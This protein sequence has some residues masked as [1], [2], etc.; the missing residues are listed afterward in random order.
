MSKISLIIPCYNEEKN[1]KPLFDE[2]SRLQ[3]KIDVELVIINNGSKD[4]TQKEIHINKKKIKKIKI[5]NI[6][7]NIGFGNGVKKGLE[8]SASKLVCYTH[9]DLQF[10]LD[11]IIKAYKIFIFKKSKKV[12]VKGLRYNRSFFD[13][14]FTYG[15][16]FLNTI[17]F[18]KLLYDIH[19]Q[20]NLFHKSML[21][22]INYLPNDMSLD[23][24]VL[25]CAKIRNYE[26]IRFK[27]KVLNRK[28]GVGSND[29]L[30]KKIKY[31]LL[32]IFSSLRIF[33]NGSF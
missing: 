6:K 11:E 10:K 30:S 7:N 18:R 9:G 2:V 16:S 1:I 23:L 14:F 32:S 33:F 3:K 21:K 15:M 22:K 19:A 26:V 31:S 4:E 13:T 28:Y 24:Y 27:L 20:P 12:M 8:I 25:L 5:I 29:S 17:I